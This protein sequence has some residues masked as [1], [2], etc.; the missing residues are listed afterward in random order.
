M[1]ELAPDDEGDPVTSCVVRND[2]TAV[3]IQRV[4]VPQGENQRLV[5]EGIRGLFKDGRAGK[6][7]APAL[8][9]CIELETAVLAGAGRLA[10]PTD[11][12]TSRARLA[13]SG[14][15]ARGMLGLNEG[16]LWHS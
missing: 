13:I 1:V 12:R 8:R 3:D 5:Y 11:K 15:V 14:L 7:G 6:P 10:C 4:K 9:P 2:T 16:W